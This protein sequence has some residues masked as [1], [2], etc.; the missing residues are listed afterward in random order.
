MKGSNMATRHHLSDELRWRAIGRLEA[1]QRQVEV[2]RWL[3]VDRSVVSR[4]WNKFQRTQNAS[5]S[6]SGGRPRVTS[7]RDDRYIRLTSRRNRSA[8]ATQVRAAA[9]A[10]TGRPMSTSTVRRRLHEGGLYARRPVL[11][12]PLTQFHKTARLRWAREHVNWT[13][14]QWRSV[15]FTDESRFSLDSDSRR[16]LV[17][18]EAGTRYHPSNIVERDR[19]GGAGVLV[20]G[21]ISIGGRTD[22]YVLPRGTMTGQ[23]YRDDVLARHVEPF[24]RDHGPGFI[25]QDDNA[26]PHR[27]RLVDRFLE[28]HHIQ[29]MVWPSRSPDLNPIEHMWDALGRRVAGLVPPPQTLH[30]LQRS[31]SQQW[32]LIPNELVDNLIGSMRRRCEACIAVRGDHI[33]Y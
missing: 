17:W 3:N 10:A 21:G 28:E 14:D 2:A 24:A 7:V 5:R 23:R 16:R 33:P 19:Y 15:L 27:A 12:I 25:L 32:T 8:T 6:Y 18:R 26:R 20:W 4:L 11:C 9:I 29:R 13:L 1:G 30:D 31:L 22:L